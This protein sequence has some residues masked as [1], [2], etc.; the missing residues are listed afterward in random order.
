MDFEKYL[1][2][3]IE[4]FRKLNI[5]IIKNSKDELVRKVKERYRID[6]E[7]VELLEDINILLSKRVKLGFTLKKTNTKT[8]EEKINMLDEK[9]KEKIKEKFFELNSNLSDMKTKLEEILRVG[10]KDN[11]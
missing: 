3:D 4:D 5:G 9:R 11:G 8:I 1:D 7:V 10:D 2:K 6:D